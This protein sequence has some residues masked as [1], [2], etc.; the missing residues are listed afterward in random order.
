[1]V[2][3]RAALLSGE[4]VAH[5]EALLAIET[6]NFFALQSIRVDVIVDAGLHSDVGLVSATEELVFERIASLYR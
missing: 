3:K 4:L 6:R 1:M 5:F 2:G